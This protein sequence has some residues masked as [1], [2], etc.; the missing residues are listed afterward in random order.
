MKINDTKLKNIRQR[1]WKIFNNNNRLFNVEIK[2][3]YMDLYSENEN[4]Y[5]TKTNI[6]NGS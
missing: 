5:N 6:E 2:K 1:K 3:K 4:I